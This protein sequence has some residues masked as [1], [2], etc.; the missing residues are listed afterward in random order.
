LQQEILL[1]TLNALG[2]IVY[3]IDMETEKILFANETCKKAFGEIIGK[4]CYSA[5]HKLN[6][7][8]SFCI[9][10]EIP[11]K[12]GETAEW[13]Y[14]NLSNGRFYQAHDTVI[15]WT[16]GKMVKVQVTFDITDKKIAEEKL[17][18]SETRFRSL[19]EGHRAMMYIVDPQNGILLDMNN[20][21]AEF[22]GYT[23]EELRGE[24]ISKIHTYTK[25]QID[26]ARQRAAVAP[27]TFFAV[28]HRLRNGEIRSMEIYTSPVEI[29]GKKALFSILHDVTERKK[30]EDALKKAK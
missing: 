7:T 8:C 3:V 27:Q 28:N 10:K 9:M 15:E 14:Q 20:A 12:L 17:K 29:D 18:K 25:E 24:H 5:I 26:E 6:E 1:K 23:P 4:E 22:Y 13:E 21:A 11:K 16:G 30:A 19:F 2:A